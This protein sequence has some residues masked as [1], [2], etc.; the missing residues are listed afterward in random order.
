MRT[1][2]IPGHSS[3]ER[4]LTTSWMSVA[5]R[6][7]GGDWNDRISSIVF[8]NGCRLGN[9]AI[10]LANPRFFSCDDRH[11]IPGTDGTIASRRL[12]SSATSRTRTA[13]MGYK[14]ANTASSGERR[15][16]LIWSV[17]CLRR[18]TARAVKCRRPAGAWKA[19]PTAPIFAPCGMSGAKLSTAAFFQIDRSETR[20]RIRRCG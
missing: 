20:I 16:P 3:G 13:A 14:P 11:Q 19:A 6:Y 17:R 18:A 15:P 9:T 10:S 8:A 5:R 7:V 2:K 1:T 12:K 4:V